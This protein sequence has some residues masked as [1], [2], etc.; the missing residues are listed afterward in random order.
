MRA[1][2]ELSSS[3]TSQGPLREIGQSD[4]EVEEN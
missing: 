3:G 1:D 4:P 2:M